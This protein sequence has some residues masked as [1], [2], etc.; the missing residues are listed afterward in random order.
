MIGIMPSVP[1][2]LTMAADRYEK[3]LADN[4][5]ITL[6]ELFAVDPDELPV[7]RADNAGLITG[8]DD[9]PWVGV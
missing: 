7:T 4:D 5:K 6:S 9:V 3:A 2:T 1:G 8:H